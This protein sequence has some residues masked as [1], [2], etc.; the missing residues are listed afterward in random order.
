MGRKVVSGSSL[1]Q[2]RAITAVLAV[3]ALVLAYIIPRE[4]I[5]TLV[6]YVWAGIGGTFSVVILLTLF[7]KKYNG[8]AVVAT[9]IS[10]LIFTIVWISTGLEEVI[11][12]RLLTFF[13]AGIIAI[14]ATFLFP[15]KAGK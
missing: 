6:S 14:F 1:L 15:V 7:W 9:I 11:T 3:L 5:F 10:G 12:S 13:V 8:K 2:S 4:Y